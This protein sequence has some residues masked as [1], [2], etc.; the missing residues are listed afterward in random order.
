MVFGGFSYNTGVNRL[1][2][3]NPPTSVSCSRSK[4]RLKKPT[5]P[6]CEISSYRPISNLSF[7]SK[8]LER[9]ASVQLTGFLSAAGLLPVHQSAYRRFHSI[10]T[11]PPKGGT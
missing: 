7:L 6:P 4:P 10:E 2:P 3:P 9:V 5:L 1:N 8:L 11:A